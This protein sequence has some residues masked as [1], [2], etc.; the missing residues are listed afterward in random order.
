MGFEETLA[1]YEENA[2]NGD[3]QFAV[4]AALMRLA[5][6]QG[7]MRVDLVYGPT[8]EGGPLLKIAG[9]LERLADAFE[10]RPAQ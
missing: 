3:G 7:Q 5:T 8:G 9:S 1:L 4:A 10:N 2:R 6:A